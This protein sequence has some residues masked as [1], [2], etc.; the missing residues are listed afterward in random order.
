MKWSERKVFESTSL[1]I[2]RLKIGK[3]NIKKIFFPLWWIISSGLFSLYTKSK[4]LLEAQYGE[5]RKRRRKEKKLDG[6]RLVKDDWELMH[7]PRA[8]GRKAEMAPPLLCVCNI[9][10]KARLCQNQ[11]SAGCTRT[12]PMRWNKLVLF[13]YTVV[14]SL[15]LDWPWRIFQYIAFIKI[16]PSI[17]LR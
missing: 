11:I 4:P 17:K 5:L 9:S 12:Q 16:K 14:L 6:T 15:P 1:K 3:K 2:P 7:T 8:R 10:V 13:L